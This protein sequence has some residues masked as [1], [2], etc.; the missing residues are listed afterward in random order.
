VGFVVD[1][2]AL[3]QAF[4]EY[5]GFLCK[6]SFNR[7]IHTITIIVWGWYN[8]SNSGLRAKW[9]QSQPTPRNK[10]KNRLE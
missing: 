3:G 6:F 4:S 5:I 9:T 8:R 7:P 2:V 1:K 10:K